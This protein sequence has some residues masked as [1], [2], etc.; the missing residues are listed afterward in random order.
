MRIVIIYILIL[1]GGAAYAQDLEALRKSER[2]AYW[3][4]T[5][6][7]SK[8]SGNVYD[9]VYQHISLAIDPL[10]RSIEGNV[11]SEVVAE[12]DNFTLIGYDL[13]TNMVVDSVYVNGVKTNFQRGDN[14]VS[15]AV[16]S[17]RKGT[18]ISTRVF[19]HGDPSKSDQRAFSY[20][21]QGDGAPVCWTLSQPYGAYGWWPCKQQL[22]DKIDSLDM[23][24][25]IPKG[26]KAAGMGILAA[27][28]TLSDSSLI[29]HWQH[30]HPIA[31]YLVAT[32]VTVYT[33]YVHY[34]PLFGGDSVLNIDYIYPV[35]TETADTLRPAID[36]LMW[37]F[38]S[39]FGPYP[40]KDEKHGHAMFNRGGGMEHQ[41]MSFMSTMDFDLMAH[42]LGHQWFGNKITCAS[43]QDLWLN[44]GW[45]TYTNALGREFVRGK[46]SFLEFVIESMSRSTRNNG[47]SVYAYDTTSVRDLFNGD[48]RYRKG[49]M[50]LHQL[51]WEVGDSAFFAGT[52]NYMADAELCFGF[53][54]TIDFQ[55][56]IENASGQ[57]LTGF[58][59]RY[60]YQ[61]GF[62]EIVTRW[63]RV[64][65][66]KLKLDLTQTTSHPSVSFFPV[67]IQY[68]LEGATQDTLIVVDHRTAT[69]EWVVDVG[70]RVSAISYDPNFWLISKGSTIEGNHQ[71][72][73]S[74]TV[75]PNPTQNTLGVYLKDKRISELSVYDLQ[76]KLVLNEKQEGLKGQVIE[77]DI[78]ALPNGIYLLKVNADNEQLTIKFYKTAE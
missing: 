25:H 2:D 23:S 9:V 41:T 53:A 20:D 70:F 42:E 56:A 60:V 35:Y 61:E 46:A 40:F 11:Y 28:D 22:V 66:N 45:A 5:Q 58:F 36:K 10:V 64:G 24:I 31:T 7:K 14:E 72:L 76:G 29:F 6:F 51:R 3:A 75:F 54:H 15:I 37:A 55:E 4:K 19:Y 48:Q 78:S 18:R 30:R 39:L 38:D 13:T 63:N 8:R 73:S 44:E 65:E 49:A 26:N 50:V 21:F 74:V 34:I 59:D 33:E 68:R 1:V 16:P 27:V 17:I 71:D 77:Q 43:W 32:A 62:P 67:R 57:N 47:G 69:Q 52:R 12:E